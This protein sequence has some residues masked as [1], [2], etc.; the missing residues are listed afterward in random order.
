MISLTICRISFTQYYVSVETK[1]AFLPVTAA[2]LL[3]QCL[4]K[5]NNL[6]KAKP[7]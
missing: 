2:K 6:I 4:K 1:I 7:L 5:N 3:I